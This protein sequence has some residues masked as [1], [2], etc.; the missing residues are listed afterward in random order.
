MQE[1]QF[2]VVL[3]PLKNWMLIQEVSLNKLNLHLCLTM[4]LQSLVGEKKTE[5]NIGS[6]ETVGELIGVKVD[7]SESECTNTTLVLNSI[8][9]GEQLKLNQNRLTL[10]PKLK[11]LTC[12]FDFIEFL[13]IL[14][15]YFN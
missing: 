4:K 11:L 12:D 1:D 2:H 14:T 10:R 3:M 15:E 13:L 7:F 6:Q 8:V 5:P 9:L